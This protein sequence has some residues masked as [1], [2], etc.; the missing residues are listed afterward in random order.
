MHGDDHVSIGRLSFLN[1]LEEC[2][3]SKYQ[4]KTQMLGFGNGKVNEV[5]ILNRIVRLDQ[6]QGIKYEVDSRH[7][8]AIIEKVGL[9][10]AKAVATPGAREEGRT[11]D[12]HREPPGNEHATKYRASLPDAT[13]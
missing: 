11:P 6:Q 7:V 5:K 2:L 12:D 8:G 9:N 3:E 10:E 1:L 4:I 13:T